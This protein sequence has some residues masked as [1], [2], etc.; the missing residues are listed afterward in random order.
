V[1]TFKETNLLTRLHNLHHS[2]FFNKFYFSGK[3]YYELFG[4]RVFKEKPFEKLQFDL[5]LWLLHTPPLAI[6]A[7]LN[8]SKKIQAKRHYSLSYAPLWP[9]RRSSLS[10][11][12]L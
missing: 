10:Y 6:L 11:A 5:N 12:P 8:K 1:D 4:K 9:K 7:A 2:L 3:F